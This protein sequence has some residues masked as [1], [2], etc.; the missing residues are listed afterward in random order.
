M[1]LKNQMSTLLK[2]NSI[3]FSELRFNFDIL[4]G[5]NNNYETIGTKIDNKYD[6]LAIFNVMHAMWYVLVLNEI[7]V[8][9]Y[10]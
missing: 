2:Y 8:L 3:P 9:M 5:K 6:N 7:Q 4:S 10:I 1:V